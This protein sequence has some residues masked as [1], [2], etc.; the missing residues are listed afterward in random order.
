MPKP[1]DITGNK[2]GKLTA[3]EFAYS[4]TYHERIWKCK[5]D[6]GNDAYVS[7][8][9]LTTGNTKSCGCLSR[10]VRHKKKKPVSNYK[11]DYCGCD[12]YVTPYR[13]KSSKKHFCKR[14]CQ[15]EYYRAHPD[16]TANYK[17]R[18]ETERF[19]AAKILRLR[20]SA[21]KRNIPFSDR[22]CFENLV[23]LWN[24][25]KGLCYYTGIKMSFCP[26]DA[27]HLVSVDRVDNKIGYEP[28]NIVLCCCAFNALKFSYNHNGVIKFIEEIKN[29]AL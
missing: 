8:H 10:Y 13:L 4:N 3:I 12:I 11:C 20:A 24:N 22:L 25:Q 14:K 16:E 26:D 2:Y 29:C 28:E 5:C 15:G 9:S 1:K 17:E 6:C 19:F 21:R 18:S 7:I 27:M 23:D